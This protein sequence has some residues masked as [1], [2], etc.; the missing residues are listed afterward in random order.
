MVKF[1]VSWNSRSDQSDILRADIEVQIAGRDIYSMENSILITHN[2]A[3]HLFVRF[4]PFDA[5]MISIR[6]LA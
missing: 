2:H 4:I 1:L 3:K 6:D 5:R